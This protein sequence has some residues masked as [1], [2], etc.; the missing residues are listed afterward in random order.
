MV[1]PV[2]VTLTHNSMCST[3]YH[4]SSE[5]EGASRTRIIRHAGWQSPTCSA[6]GPG[7]STPTKPGS[8]NASL[9]LLMLLFEHS[10]AQHATPGWGGAE[11]A[12]LADDDM[13]RRKKH[14][15]AH[16]RQPHCGSC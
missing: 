10:P 6:P 12:A 7:P 4:P 14:S 11:G 5:V 2:G 13:K 9:L 16:R 8:C 15:M 1:V 3:S